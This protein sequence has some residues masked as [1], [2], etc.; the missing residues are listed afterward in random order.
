M[1]K[2]NGEKLPKVSIII[3]NYNEPELTVR[4]L[5]SVLKIEYPD[6]EIILVDN[7]SDNISY[8]KSHIEEFKTDKKIELIENKNNLGYAEGN[9]TG[10]KKSKGD[11]ILFLNNDVIVKK[12][13][14][15]PLVAA[16]MSNEKIGAVQPKILMLP[17]RDTID[18]VG[19][20]FLTSGF[21]YHFG[22]NKKDQEK[23]QNQAEIFT[24]KGACMLF[25]KSVLEKTGVFDK[26]YFAYYEETDLCQRTWIAGYK[27]LYIPTSTIYH[28]GGQTSNKFPSDFVQ[29]HSYKNRIFTHCKNLEIKTLM[30]VLPSHL[31]L[32]TFA[33]IM[34]CVT[35]KF[36]LAYCI[37]KSIFWNLFNLKT[38][39]KRRREIKNLRKVGDNEYLPNVT[40]K[41]RASY[42]YHLF[43]TALSGYQ[44]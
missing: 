8:L 44:D 18:S 29:F 20:Y 2:R 35:G 4:C 9:N 30:K 36:S 12:D 15:K 27:I 37:Q 33:S 19:S 41:V 3:L 26:E 40:K 23:Y 22:H 25:K 14:L 5:E 6:F 31:A 43:T 13:F 21:L 17:K 7:G 42:Y 38:I 28:K 16:L 34:Y 11:L 39:L 24:M 32:C 1:K 10:Y